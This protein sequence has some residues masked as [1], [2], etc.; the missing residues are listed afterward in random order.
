MLHSIQ[1]DLQHTIEYNI[2]RIIWRNLQHSIKQNIQRNKLLNIE[3]IL[4]HKLI[5]SMQH[6]IYSRQHNKNM[7]PSNISHLIIKRLHTE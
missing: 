2:Q 7:I 6:N 1:H 4:K 3:H 5:C